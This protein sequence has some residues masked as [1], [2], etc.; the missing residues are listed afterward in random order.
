MAHL[1]L[2]PDSIDVREITFTNLLLLGF[3]VESN[4]TQYRIPFTR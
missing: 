3:D 4:E 2:M 1:K